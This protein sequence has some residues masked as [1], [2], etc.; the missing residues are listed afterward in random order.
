MRTDAKLGLVV[1]LVVVLVG[2]GYFLFGNRGE[3]PIE[4]AASPAGAKDS[5]AGKDPA[6]AAKPAVSQPKRTPDRVAG[7]A[8]AGAT[9]VTPAK[10]TTSTRPATG[11]STVMAP[12]PSV[13]NRPVASPSAATPKTEGDAARQAAAPGD[14]A[15]GERKVGEP[16]GSNPGPAGTAANPEAARPSAGEGPNGTTGERVVEKPAVTG[17]S[18]T[19]SMKSIAPATTPSTR[20][21]SSEA[22]KPAVETH[23]VQPGETF[24]TLARSYYGDPLLAEFLVTVN[25]QLESGGRLSPG[26]VVN[27]PPSPTQAEVAQLLRQSRERIAAGTTKEVGKT[28][29]AE[30]SKTAPSSDAATKTSPATTAKT[31]GDTKRTYVVKSGDTFYGIAK[32]QLGASSRWKELYEMNKSVVKG[33]PKSLKPGQVIVLPEAPAKAGA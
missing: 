29:A 4:L 25:P 15:V 28:P 31:P 19:E 13:L 20:P 21:L 27:I 8:P 11:D 7:G 33:D 2:G 9:P 22:R 10:P 30:T 12:L 32:D 3:A 18:D 6:P 5:P 26:M 14:S 23:R 24:A 17:A 1:G 16:A